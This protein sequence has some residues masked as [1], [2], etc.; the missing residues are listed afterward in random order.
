M[1]YKELVSA[2]IKKA[3]YFLTVFCGIILLNVGGST[4]FYCVI[5]TLYFQVFYRVIWEDIN[6]RSIWLPEAEIAVKMNICKF[7]KQFCCYYK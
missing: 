7:E 1:K 5:G 3:Y 6:K 2:A 4:F